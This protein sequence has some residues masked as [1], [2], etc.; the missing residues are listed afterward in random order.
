MS[1]A[2]YVLR[3]Y[4]GCE[5]RLKSHEFSGRFSHGRD[6]EIIDLKCSH[7]KSGSRNVGLTNHAY[8]IVLMWAQF[9]WPQQSD[10]RW[11]STANVCPA[12]DLL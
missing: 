4:L 11:Y 5:A 2:I 1:G 9:F 7:S 8:S 10:C 3:K 12:D 6:G